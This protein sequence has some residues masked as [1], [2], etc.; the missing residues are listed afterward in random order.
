MEKRKFSF[1]ADENE[2]Y[3]QEYYR[4]LAEE[5]RMQEVEANK[6]LAAKGKHGISMISGNSTPIVG[7]KNT[8]HIA[9]WYEDTPQVDRN[10]ALVTWELFKKRSNGKFTPTNIKKTG[11]GTFTFGE[12]SIRN[13][14]RLEA[15]LYRPEGGGLIINPKPSAIP[16]IGKVE[17]HYVD[18]KKSDT[19]SFYDRL[20]AK[21]HTIG[22]LRKELIFILW[23]DDTKGGGH[24]ACNPPMEVK[25]ARVQHNGRAVDEFKC[26]YLPFRC[27]YL[28]FRSLGQSF[29]SFS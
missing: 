20:R 29:K 1:L 12:M 16:K 15:Y 26:F 21:A 8:Y 3:E 27:F 25:S 13:T 23:E 18:D 10:P 7:E 28:P 17:L 9:G 19:F 22:M 5:K 24:S 14:Y 4:E 2:K 6:K 11:D